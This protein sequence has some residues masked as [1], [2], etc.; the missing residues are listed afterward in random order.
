MARADLRPLNVKNQDFPSSFTA[1]L[2]HVNAIY[3][4][5]NSVTPLDRSRGPCHIEDLRGSSIVPVPATKPAST[6]R[7]I[8]AV[9]VRPGI[10]LEHVS[11]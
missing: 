3:P 8:E 1:G 4:N 7:R 11:R 9:S 10:Q 6:L 2:D 5:C